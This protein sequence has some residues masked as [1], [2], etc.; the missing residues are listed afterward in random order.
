[1]PIKS[2]ASN[3]GA[4][5]CFILMVTA[6]AGATEQAP[7]PQARVEHP[8]FTFSPVIAGTEVTHL[9]TIA[10][11]GDAPLNIPGVHVG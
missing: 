8:V 3:A 6:Y 1:M 5:F 7:L 4:I 9:F 11:A 2:G 10:N